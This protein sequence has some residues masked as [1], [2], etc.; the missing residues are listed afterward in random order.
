MGDMPTSQALTQIN[1]AIVQSGGLEL[2]DVV[3]VA[4]VYDALSSKRAYKDAWSE[5][6]VFNELRKGAG[7]HFDP[8][9]IEAFFS[10]IDV[11][12]SLGRRYSE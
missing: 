10:V 9:V 5:E 11:I 4:D 7:K 1:A 2:S 8:E 12:R 6:D 3:A